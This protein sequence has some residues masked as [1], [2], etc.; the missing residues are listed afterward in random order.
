MGVASFKTLEG[1]GS[2]FQTPARFGNPWD[3]RA[4]II[5]QLAFP[6]QTRVHE[7]D[8]RVSSVEFRLGVDGHVQEVE[9]SIEFVG[10]QIIEDHLLRDLMGKVPQHDR[11]DTFPLILDI[12][13]SRDGWSKA[14]YVGDGDTCRH[15]SA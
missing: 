15:A 4:A 6:S 9:R 11:R 10:Y 14:P 3:S 5:A 7:I 8:E 2:H 1:R 13:I 12:L